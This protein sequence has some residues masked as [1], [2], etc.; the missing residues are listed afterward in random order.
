MIDYTIE[1]SKKT[2]ESLV[3]Y[4][5]RTLSHLSS[6]T[7][8]NTT[9]TKLFEGVE[10]ILRGSMS[11]LAP[12]DQAY[13]LSG[14]NLSIM[15]GKITASGYNGTAIFNPTVNSL[16]TYRHTIIPQEEI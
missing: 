2:F 9:K 11:K 7:N 15:C 10:N 8:Q 5:D 16:F 4:A 14:T 6:F 12:G 13:S 1:F 3:K